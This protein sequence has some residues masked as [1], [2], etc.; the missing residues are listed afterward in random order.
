[1]GYSGRIP[2]AI[3]RAL[4][5]NVPF[6]YIYSDSERSKYYS[7]I[8]G[9]KIEMM[10]PIYTEMSGFFREYFLS[11]PDDL[12]IGFYEKGSESIPM[13][14][15]T[16]RRYIETFALKELQEGALSMVDDF[17]NL[18]GNYLKSLNYDS[19][20]VSIPFESFQRKSMEVDKKIFMTSYSDDLVYGGVERIN[21][22]NL[23]KKLQRYVDTDNAG[24][25][26]S[27]NIWNEETEKMSTKNTNL[28][29]KDIPYRGISKIYDYIIYFKDRFMTVFGP[30]LYR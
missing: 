24:E 30:R 25:V 15:K 18:F 27:S 14:V 17:M 6:L 1:M 12:C 23:W 29:S 7:D 20:Q 8:I 3:N 5:Y 26:V 21:V 2:A 22:Y 10:Y 11:D 28:E 16:N 19:F 9:T 4:G 13:L